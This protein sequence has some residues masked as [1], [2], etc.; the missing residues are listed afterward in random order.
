MIALLAL[1]KIVKLEFFA[2]F[3]ISCEFP[4]FWVLDEEIHHETRRL[5]GGVFYKFKCIRSGNL[6]YGLEA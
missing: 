3:L 5:L 6:K 2:L 4:T 1:E